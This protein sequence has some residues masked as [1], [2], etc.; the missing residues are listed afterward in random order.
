MT[1]NDFD[2]QKLGG[3]DRR[4][5]NEWRRLERGF[6]PEF[7]CRVL[8]TN[9]LSL[10]TSYLVEYHIHSF[11]GVTS[12]E[13][14]NHPGVCN[15]P[16]FADT[17]QM[18]IDLPPNYPCVDA[19]PQ[20]HFLTHDSDGNPIP[21]PWHPNIRYFGDFAGRVCI[22]LVDTYTDILWGVQRVA[23]YLHYTCYHALAEPP[24]PEDLQVAAW[25]I[26]QAEPQGWIPF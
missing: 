12:I 6:D 26:R 23:T 4:L 7:Q 8:K 19:P 20:F 5:L 1:S 15:S 2:I 17:F 25:V 24:Y 10:P 3:R 9:A 18:Q 14:L 22:N 11:C 13:Q 21:H 16:I